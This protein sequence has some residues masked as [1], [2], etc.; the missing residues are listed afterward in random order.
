M[1]LSV[2]IGFVFTKAHYGFGGLETVGNMVDYFFNGTK[3]SYMFFMW[4][5][6]VVLEL[7]VFLI[8]AFPLA[9]IFLK[10]KFGTFGNDQI[11]AGKLGVIAAGVVLFMKKRG[12]FNWFVSGN[13][14]T[15]NIVKQNMQVRNFFINLSIL[16]CVVFL[17][18]FIS[19]YTGKYILFPMS[20]YFRDADRGSWIGP[21]EEVVQFLFG[22]PV[23]Y[24]FFVGFL[25]T[26]FGKG[27][28]LYLYMFVFPALLL[29]V[30]GGFTWL[31]WA[32]VF[33]ATGIFIAKLINKITAL[34][35]KK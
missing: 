24:A 4:P 33:F 20:N 2:P 32:L 1:I 18:Y 9:I 14:S 5:L 21:S 26:L 34:F 17:T 16:A 10:I 6:G 35:F 19:Y 23:T 11:I 31:L 15:V 30:M 3:I 12:Y 27:R 29:S 28:I 22:M 8:V 25:S 13:V 7:P